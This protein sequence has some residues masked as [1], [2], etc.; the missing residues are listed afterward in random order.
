MPTSIDLYS[1]VIQSLPNVNGIEVTPEQ[2]FSYI[3][4]NFNSF[5]DPNIAPLR[6]YEP[7]D[8]LQWNSNNPLNTA[9]TFDIK[10]DLI[11]I[12]D[13]GVMVTCSTSLSWIFSTIQNPKNFQHPVS[14]NRYFGLSRNLDGTYTFSI[15]GI[16]RLTGMADVQLGDNDAFAEAH[17]LWTRAILSIA[18]GIRR[19]GGTAYVPESYSAR[20]ILK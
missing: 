7:Q 18:D 10:K 20:I 15:K 8:A 17:K 13:A 2:L 5:L 6:A 12:D 9:M 14:G 1:V 4:I 11:N 19:Q 3:R 16:D